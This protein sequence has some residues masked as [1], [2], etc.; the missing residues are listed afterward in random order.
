MVYCGPYDK[1]SKNGINL[2]EKRLEIRKNVAKKMSDIILQMDVTMKFGMSSGESVQYGALY[3]A[4]I[5]MPRWGFYTDAKTR[6]EVIRVY[7]VRLPGVVLEQDDMFDIGDV[8]LKCPRETRFKVHIF[9]LVSPDERCNNEFQYELGVVNHNNIVQIPNW[10]DLHRN[11]ISKCD[12]P[13]LFY[14]PL[15]WMSIIKITSSG[16]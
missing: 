1:S 11:L 9:H 16:A 2:D 12:S 10:S 7:G 3:K 6:K 4:Y 15:A 14:D 13:F 8:K 5:A